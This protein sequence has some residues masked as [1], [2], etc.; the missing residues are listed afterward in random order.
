[1]KESMRPE[2][3]VLPPLRP[4]ATVLLLRDGSDGLEVFMVRRHEGTAFMGG[5]QVFP[6]GRVEHSDEDG[7]ETWCDGIARARQLLGNG[8]PARAI[9]YHVAAVRELFEEAGVLLARA[10]GGDLELVSFKDERTQE[11]FTRHRGEI[12]GGRSTIRGVVVAERLRL[13]LDVLIPFAH[14]VTPPGDTRRF[15]TR[16][17][18]TRAPSQQTPMHDAAET[19][20]SVWLTATAAIQQAIDDEIVLPPPTWTTLREIERCPSVDEVLSDAARRVIVR[21]EPVVVDHEGR[22]MLVLPGDP[23]HPRVGPP[24]AETRFV[25]DRG[26]WCAERSGT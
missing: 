12:H 14:W 16:F 13:A 20:H 18:V 6:G 2:S 15:D 24:L 9:G 10:S 23:L 19:T 4:A 8:E 1:M 17:F 5:A 3:S 11:R 25:F 21:R 26:R 22:R 7:D